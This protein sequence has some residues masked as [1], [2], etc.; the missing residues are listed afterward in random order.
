MA[1]LPPPGV[2]DLVQAPMAISMKRNIP[3]LQLMNLIEQFLRIQ[4]VFVFECA[5][6]FGTGAEGYIACCKCDKNR[7]N[8]CFF[9][10]ARGFCRGGS[11][12]YLAPCNFL[13]RSLAV[14][15]SIGFASRSL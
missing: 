15:V 5:K 13:K 7:V 14:P 4:F 10:L 12:Y 8:S 2:E 1:L 6:L 11:G 9:V 3:F